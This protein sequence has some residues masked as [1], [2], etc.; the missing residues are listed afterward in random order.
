MIAALIL[1]AALVVIPGDV[2]IVAEPHPDETSYIQELKE[3]NMQYAGGR[4]I[5]TIVLAPVFAAAPFPS[6]TY[7]PPE[8][9]DAILRTFFPTEAGR[10]WARR[11]GNCESSWQLDALGRLGEI[12]WFQHRPQFWANRSAWAGYPGGDIWDPQINTAVAA[13]MFY[14]PDFGPGHWSCK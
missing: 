13:W 3:W 11:V 2:P 10:T 8:T 5:Q 1:T 12:G 4:E 14:N 7:Y 9:V 6:E